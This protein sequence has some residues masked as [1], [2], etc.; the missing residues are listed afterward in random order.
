[1]YDVGAIAAEPLLLEPLRLS[2]CSGEAPGYLRSLK[3]KLTARCNL[4]CMMCRYGRGS[5]PEELPTA[6]WCELLGE[7]A[8][9]GCRKVHLSG[10]EILVR[11][12][13]EELVAQAGAL[14]M[15]VTLS[16]NLTLLTKE[17]AKR[18]FSHTISGLSTSLDGARARTH[19]RMR[20]VP[21]C[22]RQTLKALDQVAR[23]R[24]FGRPKLRVNF[25]MTR[26]NFRE[27]PDLVR[28]A[29]EHG[30]VDVVPMP[31]DS[32]RAELR[33][34]KR[35]I[36]EYNQEI[37]PRVLEERAAAR[38]PLGDR[39][40]HPF[41]HTRAEIGLSSAG[42]YAVGYYRAHPCYAP[43]LH[44]FVAW[45]GRVYPCCM[46]N[47]RIPPLGDLKQGSLTQI[48]R[49][50]RF[51]VLRRAMLGERLPACHACDMWVEENRLLGAALERP[52]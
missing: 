52:P 49:G 38:M 24:T 7:A 19:E 6:R 23:Y 10:G 44:A 4:R 37:A 40:V 12:D 25:V 31:V 16:S 20:G 3:L 28:L 32:K 5:A 33:L 26:H 46:T 21:G 8:A 14:R 17:R 18:L 35:L 47:G 22:F 50:E 11:R 29:A 51:Q 30:A 39:Q 42:Q 36:A 27:Y 43:F 2:V 45:D 15:K 34:S 9:L 13:L 1:V 41:G 48:L